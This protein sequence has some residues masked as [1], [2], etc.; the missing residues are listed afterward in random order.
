MLIIICLILFIAPVKSK[1]EMVQV[2]FEYLKEHSI[3]A[4]M[5]QNVT[6]DILQHVVKDEWLKLVELCPG[7]DPNANIK[8][9]FDN[10]LIGSNTLAWASQ[11]LLLKDL[12]YWVP[13]IATIDFFGHDFMIGVNPQPPNGWYTFESCDSISFRYDLRTV[14]RHEMLHGIGIGSSLRNNNGWSV[15]HW[16]NSLCF[17]R[18]FDTLIVTKDNKHVVSGCTLTQDITG[19]NVYLDGVKLFNPAYYMQGSSLSHHVYEDHLLYY[20]LPP[21]KCL[22]YSDYEFKMLSALGLGCRGTASASSAVAFVSLE[23]LPISLMLLLFLL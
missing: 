23:L 17:P 16:W 4:E 21:M 12:S 1:V 18:Y 8:A 2:D 14:L 19:L 5:K 9:S 22:D 7:L 10:T 11:S 13:S 6:D 3:S 20:M 15:G